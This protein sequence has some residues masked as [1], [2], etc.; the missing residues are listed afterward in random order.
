MKKQSFITCTLYPTLTWAWYGLI[1]IQFFLLEVENC[2]K[3]LPPFSFL[4]FVFTFS[5]LFCVKCTS[6]IFPWLCRKKNEIVVAFVLNNIL[7]LRVFFMQFKVP[8]ILYACGIPNNFDHQFFYFALFSILMSA[9]HGLSVKH[10][11][12]KFNKKIYITIPLLAY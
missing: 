3:K 8:L 2:P 5:F 6:N 12:F 7:S 11:E 9:K 1:L 10:F 4:F